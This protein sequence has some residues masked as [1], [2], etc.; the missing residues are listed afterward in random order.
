MVAQA[1]GVEN[2]GGCRIRCSDADETVVVGKIIDSE[3]DLRPAEVGRILDGVVYKHILEVKGTD[4]DAGW[5]AG[6]ARFNFRV[7]RQP[8]TASSTSGSRALFGGSLLVAETTKEAGTNRSQY[9]DRSSGR[10]DPHSELF[11]NR[12][13]DGPPHH[14]RFQALPKLEVPVRRLP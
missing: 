11:L 14:T 10:N 2:G 12:R 8:F 7:A 5:L 1:R 3:L 6:L 4:R 9:L 13:H